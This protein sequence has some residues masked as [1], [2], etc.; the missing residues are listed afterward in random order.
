MINNTVDVKRM[1]T[2]RIR[3]EM[4]NTKKS[5]KIEIARSTGLSVATCGTIL[6]EMYKSGEVLRV[7]Q[8]TPYIGRPASVFS[9]N[10]DY[11][12]VLGIYMA[13]AENNNRTIC[14]AV[15]NGIGMVISEEKIMVEAVNFQEIENHAAEILENDPLI[16]FI[17]FGFPGISHSGIVEI[18]DIKEAIGLDIEG[19]LNRRFGIPVELRNDMECITRGAYATVPNDGGS[20]VSIYFPD[21]EGNYVGSGCMIDGKIVHG[22]SKFAGEL[23][24]LLDML[25]FSREEQTAMI[26]NPDRSA[27]H[28]LASKLVMTMI[29]V[30]DPEVI[31]LLGNHITQQDLAEIRNLCGNIVSNHHIPTLVADSDIHRKYVAGLIRAACDYLQFP[32]TAF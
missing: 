1:N 25:G 5:T 24:F 15:A 20:L 19:Q 2:E 21:V 32:I 23:S 30:V 31:V 16:Q 18:C 14:Y 12:H 29:C 26:V 3:S 22:H 6:N 9:Y 13:M 8:E 10:V 28:S 17:T 4:Q 11:Q 7:E 27:F